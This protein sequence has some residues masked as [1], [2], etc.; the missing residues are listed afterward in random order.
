[1]NWMYIVHDKKENEKMHFL[2]TLTRTSL[3]VRKNIKYQWL[4]D[5]YISFGPY[6]KRK[7]NN[8]ERNFSIKKWNNIVLPI[9]FYFLFYKQNLTTRSWASS[10]QFNAMHWLF[11]FGLLIFFLANNSTGV[12]N[13]GGLGTSA[14]Y[15]YILYTC[16]FMLVVSMYKSLVEVGLLL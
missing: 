6:N 16:P 14:G 11:F 1:M 15:L 9:N 3:I 2:Y 12:N 4:L 7:S 5:I 13:C 8:L 10:L